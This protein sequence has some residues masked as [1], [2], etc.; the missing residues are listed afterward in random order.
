VIETLGILL[1]IAS[2]SYGSVVVVT[3]IP[4]TS[5]MWVLIGSTIFLRD[6]ERVGLQTVLGTACVVAGT[7]IV[8]P[9]S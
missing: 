3:P 6:M 5:P 9:G 7:V 1:G 4:S 2:L 8:A